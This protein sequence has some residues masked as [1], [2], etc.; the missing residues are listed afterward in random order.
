MSTERETE[1]YSYWREHPA[2][3][4]IWRIHE[5]GN[6]GVCYSKDRVRWVAFAGYSDEEIRELCVQCD[7]HGNPLPAPAPSLPASQPAPAAGDAPSIPKDLIKALG[8][9][10]SA[11]SEVG[12]SEAA[13]AVRI[14]AAYIVSTDAWITARSADL[15]AAR[16][17]GERYKVS[18]EEGWLMATLEAKGAAALRGAL[19]PLCRQLEAQFS[20]HRDEIGQDVPSDEITYHLAPIFEPLIRAGDAALTGSAGAG[21]VALDDSD[22]QC[23]PPQM[24]NYL[25]ATTFGGVM[26]SFFHPDWRAHVRTGNG[27]SRKHYGKYARCFDV[28][29]RGYKVTHW[30]HKPKMPLPPPPAAEGGGR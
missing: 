27:P 9:V 26:E 10:E 17:E 29:T 11:L 12:V 4:L 1:T 7:A 3:N 8:M 30:M 23:L 28:A 6:A 2:S 19:E 21:W 25:V 15:A 22:P 24:G 20:Y 18:C 13:K 5:S 14:A 16:A